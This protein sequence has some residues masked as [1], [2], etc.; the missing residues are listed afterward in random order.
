MLGTIGAR[1]PILE[2]DFLN[3]LKVRGLHAEEVRF[4]EGSELFRARLGTLVDE[5]GF[6]A[7]Y[8]GN[9]DLNFCAGIGIGDM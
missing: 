5:T 9:D 8:G 4:G 2:E 3:R 6:L 1:F 7:R